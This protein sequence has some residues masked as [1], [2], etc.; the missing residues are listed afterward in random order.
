MHRRYQ[1]D[2]P[3]RRA[4]QGRGA[5]PTPPEAVAAVAAHR[6]EAVAPLAVQAQEE[7]QG[8]TH[9]PAAAAATETPPPPPPLPHHAVQP[10]LI[11]NI[12]SSLI[13]T[14]PRSRRR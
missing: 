8:A 12:N 13:R 5:A 1:Q 4:R 6:L 11:T 9:P 14:T 7:E 2:G 10:A 3:R